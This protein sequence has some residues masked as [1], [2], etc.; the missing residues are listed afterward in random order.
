LNKHEKKLI[1]LQTKAQDCVSREK[2]VKIILKSDKTR[3][4]M[5]KMSEGV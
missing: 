5:T 4:K 1:K 3:K 2:A